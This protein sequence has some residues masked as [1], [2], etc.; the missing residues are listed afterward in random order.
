MA[1]FKILRGPSSGLDK[2]T[3]NDGWC[4]Y[5]PDTGLF[6]IDYNGTR[7]PL[8]AKDAQTLSGASLVQALNSEGLDKEILSAAAVDEIKNNLELLISAKQDHITGTE[9][10]VVVIGAN[11]SPTVGDNEALTAALIME[12]TGELS[13]TYE[14]Q[15]TSHT[16]AEIKSALDEG[17]QVY[18]RL[19]QT[20][21]VNSVVYSFKLL[22]RYTMGADIN[23][24]DGPLCFSLAGEKL[25]CIIRVTADNTWTYSETSLAST[26]HTHVKAQISDF[27]SSM[28][29]SDVYSWAKASTKPTYTAS[30]VGADASGT[31][32]SLVT[33]HNTN[34]SAHSDIRTAVS[35]AQTTA[36]NAA[37]AASTAQSTADT[38]ISNKSNPHGVTAAQ[39]GAM[40][41]V[42]SAGT[43]APSNTKLLWIDTSLGGVLKYYNGSSWTAVLSVYH[44]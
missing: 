35:N 25:D 41:A 29:A 3:I 5:T 43:S 30:E 4:Y 2:L 13:D 24:N 26:I 21:T 22:F 27:P 19:T 18:I 28:P 11:G 34:T 12:V 36:N 17:K 42:F 31:A 14:V 10:Q 7:V 20:Q 15:N 23:D 40:T 33:A 32:S 44:G 9:G 6:H 39:L 38:H 16:Y 8:N 1:L 37:S